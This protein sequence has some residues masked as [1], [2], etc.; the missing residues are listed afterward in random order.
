MTD[1]GN[2]KIR[3][4]DEQYKII[5][6]WM[7][8][9]AEIT[10]VRTFWYWNITKVKSNQ[11]RMPCKLGICSI[12][13]ARFSTTART[14]AL[15]YAEYLW[16][17]PRERSG[18]SFSVAEKSTQLAINLLHSVLQTTLMPDAPSWSWPNGLYERK[19]QIYQLAVTNTAQWS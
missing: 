14:P 9:R 15:Q 8:V 13:A 3:L 1:T 5:Y 6:T 10:V 2:W 12:F 7:A 4:E 17:L 18:R 19:A 16:V 11:K